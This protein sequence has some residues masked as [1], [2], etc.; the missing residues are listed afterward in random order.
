M[1]QNYFVWIFGKF[2]PQWVPDVIVV[3]LSLFLHLVHLL[4]ELV[5]DVLSDEVRGF[6]LLPTEW[7]QPLVLADLLTVG[8]Y[9]F[10]YLV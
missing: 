7:A 5:E 10:F 8:G 2:R 6:E 9:K 3:E 1:T 4:G